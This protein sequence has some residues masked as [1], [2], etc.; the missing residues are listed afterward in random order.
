MVEPTLR[1]FS[2]S[3]DDQID[4]HRMLDR[5]TGARLVWLDDRGGGGRDAA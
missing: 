5:A 1:S 4:C 3:T 2:S